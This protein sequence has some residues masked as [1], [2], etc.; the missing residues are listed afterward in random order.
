[1]EKLNKIKD[2]QIYGVKLYWFSLIILVGIVCLIIGSVCDLN[3]SNSLYNKNSGFGNFIETYGEGIGYL[4]GCVGGTLLFL[5]LYKNEKIAFKILGYILLILPVVLS[6]VLFGKAIG[7]NEY[8]IT[9]NKPLNYIIA[10]ILSILVCVIIYFVTNKDDKRKL[11]ISGSII[12]LSIILTVAIVNGGLKF[13]G[14]RPRYR[15]LLGDS[16]SKDGLNE[17]FLNWWQFQPFKYLSGDYHKSWPSGH[18]GIT[19]SLLSLSFITPVL[20]RNNKWTSFI[21]FIVMFI[22]TIIVSVFRIIVGAH[23]LSDVSTSII[24]VSL[25]ILLSSYIVNRIDN[26]TNDSNKNTLINE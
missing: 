4:G 12:A 11:I 16:V 26:K 21:I 25:I 1:M 2:K 6:T 13:I 9:V 3:I 17:T 8:G 7:P 24:L 22:I 14:G 10:F 5:G 20:K 18:S 15:Y 23:F 19:T